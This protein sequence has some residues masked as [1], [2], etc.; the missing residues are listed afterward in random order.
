M[1]VSFNDPIEKI[2]GRVVRDAKIS[3]NIG[4]MDDMHPVFKKD[5]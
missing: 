3:A 5:A 2:I 4:A 1:D